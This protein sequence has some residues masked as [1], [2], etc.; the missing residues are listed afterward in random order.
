MGPKAK[1]KKKDKKG[2][3]EEVDT[4][5]A[6]QTEWNSL[7]TEADRLYKLTQK[8]EHDFNEFQQQRE[9]LNYFWIVEKKKLE[10][11]RAELRNKERELQD[12]E[13]KH[14][15]EIKIYKQRLKHLLQEHQNEIT[16][17]K[18]ESEVALKMAQ[19]DN[20]ENESDVKEDKRNLNIELKEIEISHEEYIRG[21]KRE[22]DQKITFLRHEFERKANEA[23]K[24]FEAR[25]K[26]TRENLDKTRKDEIK[27]IE[28]AKHVM[29]DKLMAEHQKAFADIK[30]YY[31]DITHNNLDLIKSLKEEVK[32]LEAE[33]RKDE[34]RLHE[35]MQEN[36]K[37]SAPLKKM[38]EDV[39]RLRSELEDYKKEK[40]E[41]RT[42]K[43]QLVVVEE[44]CSTVS[45]EHEVLLQRFEELQK[46]RDDL[47]LHFKACVY[48]VKQKSGFKKLILEKKLL[49][50]QRV[51]EEKE[52]QLNEVLARANLDPSALGQVKG[53]VSDVL[54]LKN[55]ETRKLQSEA[56]RVQ[57]LQEQLKESVYA[58]LK[59]YGLSSAE[60]GF[61][62]QN[63]K[64]SVKRQKMIEV[65]ET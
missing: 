37:L 23:Q 28:E 45:W 1:G 14:Q 53:R 44:E 8:E 21:L 62:P 34:M 54:Q 30:N 63:M 33:E 43:S 50:V 61:A 15:V 40:T 56:A 7:K 60:L 35:K 59:E 12:L 11:K 65:I 22:Q 24:L 27:G 16:H 19:D 25:M 26:K 39:I 18:T 57:A 55:D 10:D 58:K 41:M 32:E 38:Q 47:K 6:D 13:E 4:N 5:N 29:I 20:R 17:K 9:K 49:A 31:N 2:E 36:R 64:D 48:D 42:V 52:A 46:E 51:Q 3:G